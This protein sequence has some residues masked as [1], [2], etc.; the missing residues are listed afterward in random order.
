MLRV[1]KQTLI[2]QWRT[3]HYRRLKAAAAW[4]PGQLPAFS[5]DCS[6]LETWDALVN[7][8]LS[9]YVSRL[10]MQH[11]YDIKRGLLYT[12]AAFFHFF[13]SSFFPSVVQFI[14]RW[15]EI[16]GDICLAWQICSLTLAWSW[17]RHCSGWQTHVQEHMQ[18][19]MLYRITRIEFH[20]SFQNKHNLQRLLEVLGLHVQFLEKS[21][22]GTFT[23]CTVC[24]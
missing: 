20:T 18:M 24:L 14:S 13:A 23:V 10:R 4:G 21:R 2:S 7:P 11:L 17:N 6:P 5:N 3:I 12:S 15:N 22:H 16:M 9:L 1:S 8:N 19:L